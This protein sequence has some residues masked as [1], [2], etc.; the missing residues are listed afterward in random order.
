MPRSHDPDT[1]LEPGP[2]R[3]AIAAILA[4]GVLRLRVPQAADGRP[5]RDPSETSKTA[6]YSLE[7]GAQEGPHEPV[8]NG[9]MARQKGA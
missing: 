1:H 8:I 9:G 6:P 2:R 7:L 4:R 5:D 3:A